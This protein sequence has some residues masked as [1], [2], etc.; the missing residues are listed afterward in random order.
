M[1][2]FG[3]GENLESVQTVVYSGNI[4][5]GSASAFLTLTN[6]QYGAIKSLYA[7]GTVSN[8]WVSVRDAGEVEYLRAGFT[9]PELKDEV[10]LGPGARLRRI[11]TGGVDLG[12][13]Y[14]MVVY[15]YTRPA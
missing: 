13:T 2:T 15:I 12:L 11:N 3:A 10:W 5:A 14:T 7:N 4:G 9:G 6:D 1:A 8:T